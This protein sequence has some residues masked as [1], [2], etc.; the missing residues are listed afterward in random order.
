MLRELTARPACPRNQY[1]SRCVSDWHGFE[2]APATPFAP[3]LLLAVVTGTAGG[4]CGGAS[5]LPSPPPKSPGHGRGSDVRRADSLGSGEAVRSPLPLPCPRT[6]LVT[7]RECTLPKSSVKGEACDRL[8]DCTLAERI[9]ALQ[10][11]QL[12]FPR[13]K[14]V[15]GHFVGTASSFMAPHPGTWA[16]SP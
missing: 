14:C 2:W 1:V 10:P 5:P 9:A 13:M 8:R 16:R 11:Q 3:P 7:R 4:A 12:R 15:P 6:T